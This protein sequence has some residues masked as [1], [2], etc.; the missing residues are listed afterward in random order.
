MI[1]SVSDAYGLLGA[2]A[3]RSESARQADA[4]DDSTENCH[5]GCDTVRISSQS[6]LLA[7]QPLL[8]PTE[9]TVRE[10][11]ETLSAS[12]DA[13]FDEAGLAIQPPVELRVDE[14][15]GEIVA[16][17]DR[18]DIEQINEL[19]NADPELRQQI[20]TTLA[21]AS[22]AAGMQES[23]KF[24]R[25]YRASSNPEQVA[26]RYAHLFGAQMPHGQALSYGTDGAQVLVDG[27]PWPS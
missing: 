22:H 6:R 13:L 5:Q 7:S 12:L 25:E 18:D 1:T 2:K 24:Q 27:Q 21:I 20:Q 16:S 4:A 9:S 14:Q 11:S 23:L 26:A 3:T 17:G 19:L 10:L 8:L 15:S